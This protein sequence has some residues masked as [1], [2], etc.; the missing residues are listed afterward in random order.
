MCLPNSPRAVGSC[1]FH[2]SRASEDGSDKQRR[3]SGLSVEARCFMGAA[4]KKKNFTLGKNL[5]T[6]VTNSLGRSGSTS[7]C[8]TP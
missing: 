2:A 5:L 8:E 6:R 4:R 3:S 7:R 1:Q